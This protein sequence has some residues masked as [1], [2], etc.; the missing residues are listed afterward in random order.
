MRSGI[1]QRIVP[2]AVNKVPLSINQDIRAYVPKDKKVLADF[3]SVYLTSQQ[4]A[5]L[6]LVKWSTTVQSINKETLDAFP[7]PL[8]PKDQQVELVKLARV[9]RKQIE[10]ERERSRDLERLVASE[11]EDVILGTKQINQ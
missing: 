10:R 6:R 1:L 2:I 8:P 3:L 4:D 11:I 9:R 7:V 5:L